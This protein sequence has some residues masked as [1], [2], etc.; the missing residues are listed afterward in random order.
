MQQNSGGLPVCANG[1]AYI[2]NVIYNIYITYVTC[3]D[4]RFWLIC[5]L[6]NSQMS[7]GYC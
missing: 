2:I 1:L 5:K 6:L 4:F 3:N 7:M